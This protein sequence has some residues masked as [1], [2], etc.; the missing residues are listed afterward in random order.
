[1]IFTESRKTAEPAGIEAEEE[2]EEVEDMPM[3][4]AAAWG[5]RALTAFST[6]MPV[7]PPLTAG[8]ITGGFADGVGDG[9]GDGLEGAE[10]GSGCATLPATRF[11][12]L[13]DLSN[14]LATLAVPFDPPGA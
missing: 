9:L 1:L 14:C 5:A 6:L 11:I 12:K 8:I 7:V 4:A 10:G 3:P 13:E 2:V